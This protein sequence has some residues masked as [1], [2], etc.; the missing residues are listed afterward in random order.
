MVSLNVH[1]LS[2]HDSGLV[3]G[4]GRVGFDKYLRSSIYVSARVSKGCGHTQEDR[5]EGCSRRA[6]R[7]VSSVNR[8]VQVD[9]LR[10]DNSAFANLNCGRRVDIY[11]SIIVG[12]V[13]IGKGSK[14]NRIG[15]G[16][17]RP[18][19]T[20]LRKYRY[21]T[22]G[23]NASALANRGSRICIKT[24]C[25][26]G[27]FDCKSTTTYRFGDRPSRMVRIGLDH[28]VT[29]CDNNSACG[30]ACFGRG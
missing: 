23:S 19:E 16:A 27:H 2:A 17:A 3:G 9:F 11:T 7:R 26:F 13:R 29:T 18:V 12:V 30:H 25:R 21:Q 15:F 14:C 20:G 5:A 8:G 10:L 24:R 28:H 6:S 1:S 4:P 22:A